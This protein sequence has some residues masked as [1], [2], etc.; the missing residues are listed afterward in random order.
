MRIE[1]AEDY[2]SNLTL[3]LDKKAVKEIE[4]LKQHYGASSKAEVIRKGLAL[5]KIA[6]Q[7][8]DTEGELI[9]RKGDRESRI[10]VR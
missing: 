10:I 4:A 5:L 3:N 8:E 1:L 9:A 7:I 6:S 2:M